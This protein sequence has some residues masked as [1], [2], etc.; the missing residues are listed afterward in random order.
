MNLPDRGCKLPALTTVSPGKEPPVSVTSKLRVARTVMLVIFGVPSMLCVGSAVVYGIFWGEVK[1]AVLAP[2]DSEVRLDIGQVH[3]EV[4]PAGENRLLEIAQGEYP[5]YVEANGRAM[6]LTLDLS[7][8]FDAFLIVLPEQCMAQVDVTEFFYGGASD[9]PHIEARH[10][11]PGV[12]EYPWSTSGFDPDSMPN[13]IYEHASAY[14]FQ[15]LPCEMLELEDAE[16]MAAL[17]W[18]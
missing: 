3:S 18:S 15:E 2:A 8:G 13:S 17:G 10:T 4:I 14:M 6:E 5:S 16:L 1:V 7:N 9:A 11:G 12:V